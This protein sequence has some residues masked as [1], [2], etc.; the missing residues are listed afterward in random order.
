[1]RF[2]R[3]NEFDDFSNP[4]PKV[5]DGSLCGFSQEGFQLGERLFYGIEV[6]ACMAAGT[7]ASH[8]Q[9][10]LFHVLPVVCDWKDC[11]E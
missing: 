7:S 4:I 5:A 3:I 9:L 2:L 10:R 6:W 8:P 11:R 1:L